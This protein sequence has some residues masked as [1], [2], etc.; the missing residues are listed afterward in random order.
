M[1]RALS[2]VQGRKFEK[3]EDFGGNAKSVVWR[4]SS[5]SDVVG[6]R[7]SL[8][9]YMGNESDWGGVRHD[10]LPL[11]LFRIYQWQGRRSFM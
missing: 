10:L 3:L 9:I 7:Q 6:L 8:E 11:Y 5:F 1:A 4:P 2:G